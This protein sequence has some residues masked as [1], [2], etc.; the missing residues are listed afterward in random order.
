MQDAAICCQQE[1]HFKYKDIS[2]LKETGWENANSDQKKAG[3]V[4]E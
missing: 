2:K 3:L 1:T 4:S